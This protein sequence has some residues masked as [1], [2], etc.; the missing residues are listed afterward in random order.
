MKIF[1]MVSALALACASPALA[2]NNTQPPKKL[3]TNFI[4]TK[5][6]NIGTAT[7]MQT[8]EGVLIQTNLQDLPP[9]RHALHIHA[10]G[11]CDPQTDFKSAGDHYAPN[12]NEHGFQSAHGPHAGDLPNQMVDSKGRLRA[13]ILAPNVTLQ[14]NGKA[15]LLD[16]DGSAL[17]LHAD[18]DDYQ[19]QP[20]GDS[21]DRIAC[22]VISN[23]PQQAM[24]EQDNSQ[25]M[26][27]STQANNQD[28]QQVN[29]GSQQRTA[30]MQNSD[31][32]GQ[33]DN[34][35]PN[36]VSAQVIYSG[37]SAHQLIGQDVYGSNGTGNDLGEIQDLVLDPN[38]Q[39]KS[40]VV[41]GG[42]FLD[43]GD[44]TFRIPWSDVNLTPGKDN[45]AV[46]VSEQ[47]AENRG[48]YDQP[49][50]VSTGPHEFRANQLIGEYARINNGR[51]FGYVSDIIF[52]KNGKAMAVLIDR[53]LAY[54][55]GTY[56][57]PFYG[58]ANGW[59]PGSDRY[60]LPFNSVKLA[61]EAPKVNKGQLED[62]SS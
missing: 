21:G 1:T 20:A 60:V 47:Q 41:N 62:N 17:V 54:G 58:P 39:V 50:A 55:G 4:N 10:V 53:D 40:I 27:S 11:K 9:G 42:G 32:Q 36:Q 22:A 7:L 23:Q 16:S 59:W 18:M 34:N 29:S 3:T 26:S 61:A 33:S 31:R 51:G 24:N 13:D 6:A 46:S 30:T 25:A 48:W 2:Q 19:S 12:G 44:S 28:N 5:G 45:V 43:I 15:T 52:N 37:W 35:A 49:E 56:G 14:P 38:G 8:P 57:Y